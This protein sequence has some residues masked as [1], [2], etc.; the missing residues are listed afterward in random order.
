MYHVAKHQVVSL[1]PTVLQHNY[2]VSLRPAK[3]DFMFYISS[4]VRFTEISQYVS[5]LFPNTESYV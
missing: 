4:R 1:L 3:T 2:Q 5:T